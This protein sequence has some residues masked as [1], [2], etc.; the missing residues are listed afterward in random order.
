MKTY[1]NIILN[2]CT[3]CLFIELVHA[4]NWEQAKKIFWN[5]HSRDHFQLLSTLKT[6]EET[7]ILNRLDDLRQYEKEV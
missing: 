3:N 6:P 4:A 5:N 7:H 1:A 2:T